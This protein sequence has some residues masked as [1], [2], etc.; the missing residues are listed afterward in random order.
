MAAGPGPSDQ[1][2][3]GWTP[4]LQTQSPAG[5]VDYSQYLNLGT[6]S[7]QNTPRP[8]S[9]G[10]ATRPSAIVSTSRMEA[11]SSGDVKPGI[12]S[13]GSKGKERDDGVARDVEGD[14][15]GE[16][17]GDESDDQTK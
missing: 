9:S 16:G 5:F 3:H 4:H 2:L 6:G 13:S 1:P 12:G 17:D 11:G 7:N 14:A 10:S 15:D 8:G